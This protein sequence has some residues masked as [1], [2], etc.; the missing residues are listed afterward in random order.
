MKTRKVLELTF[1]SDFTATMFLWDNGFWLANYKRDRV[2]GNVLRVAVQRRTE[3]QEVRN[4]ACGIYHATAK[5]LV[6]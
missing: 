1:P 3:R 2:S 6:F 4:C 5:T